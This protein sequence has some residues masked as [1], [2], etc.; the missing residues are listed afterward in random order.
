LDEIQLINLNG[1]VIQ[2]IKNPNRVQNMYTLE[3]LP[4]GFYFVKLSSTDNQTTTK[5]ILV[6]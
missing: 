5:K 3:N 2:M 1:Q 6:N 4:Q